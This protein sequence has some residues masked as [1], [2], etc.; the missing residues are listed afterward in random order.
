M[1]ETVNRDD[2]KASLYFALISRRGN[3]RQASA[4]WLQRFFSLQDP[5]NL[6]REL[7]VLIDAVA[8]GVF[9]AEGRSLCSRQFEV[10][11]KEL[12]ERAGFTEQQHDWSQALASKE[13]SLRSEEYPYLRKHCPIWGQL[14]ASLR[15]SRLHKALHTYFENIFAGEI[16]SSAGLADA[17]DEMLDNL[18]SDY[19]KDE[20]PMRRDVQLLEF[21]IEEK[22]DKVAAQRRCDVV[23]QALEAK[24][25]FTQ[26]ITNAAMHPE[27]AGATKAS[28]RFAVAMSRDWIVAAHDDLT[29]KIRAGVPRE[30]PIKI[31]SWDGK[32]QAG[33]NETELLESIKSHW[34]AEEAKRIATIALNPISWGALALGGLVTVYGL[35]NK[36]PFL[37]VVGLAGIG[38]YFYEKWKL[39]QTKVQVQTH[40]NGL[41]ESSPKILKAVLAEVVDWRKDCA[42]GDAKADELRKYFGSITTEQY[43]LSNFDS[44]RSVLNK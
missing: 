22:G 11:L 43:M 34:I 8:S 32:T 3:R 26:L 13:P 40:F 2:N 36:S 9:G 42:A 20:L 38:W 41:R 15:G 39:D 4:A 44:G 30:I 14:D 10:W 12:S 28:Q 37:I 27:V 29:A 1:I 33:E 6:D 5:V 17:V 24:Q 21:I 31:E 16:P 23:K 35:W 18:V 25:S 7:I 19:D